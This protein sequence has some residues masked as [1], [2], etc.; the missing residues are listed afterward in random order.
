MIMMPA[1]P[2]VDVAEPPVPHRGNQG[3][4]GHV[5]NVGP[6]EKGHWKSQDIQAG[7]YHPG[8]AHAEEPAY[9]PDPHAANDQ[10]RPQDSVLGKISGLQV[11]ADG[12]HDDVR[13]DPEDDPYHWNQNEG[14]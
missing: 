4:P 10:S 8:A 6:D 13:H 12:T 7:C 3:F 1:E 2:V 11:Y 9:D 14:E 5:S